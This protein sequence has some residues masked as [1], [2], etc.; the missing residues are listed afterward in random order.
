MEARKGF[1]DP[2]KRMMTLPRE[3]QDGVHFTGM[4]KLG[5][6]KLHMLHL[7][8]FLVSSFVEFIPYIFTKIPGVSSF[9]RVRINQD[10]VEKFFGMQRQAGRTNQN[11]TVAEFIKNTETLRVINSIWI[12]NIVGNCCGRKS[13]EC[14]LHAAMQPL[15]KRSR[16]RQISI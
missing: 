5:S 6:V 4:L 1:T 7:I 15:R 12:D 8:H 9:L 3:T 14:D 16:Q 10:P 11:P 13:N 2:E